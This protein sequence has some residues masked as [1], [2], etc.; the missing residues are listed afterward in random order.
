MLTYRQAEEVDH[1]TILAIWEKSVSATHEFLTAK[2]IAEIKPELE[3]YLGSLPIVLACNQEGT[4]IG[5]ASANQHHLEML[6]L[7]PVYFGQGLGAEFFDYLVATY[8]IRSLDVNEQNP[9]ARYFYLKHNFVVDA[10]SETDDQG[11]PF[12]ILHLKKA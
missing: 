2:D 6:F 9:R 3:G 10:R 1:Q 11:R 8:Q 5:F 4:V 12:P 7:D